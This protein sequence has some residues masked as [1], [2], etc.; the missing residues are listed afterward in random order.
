MKRVYWSVPAA[1]AAAAIA[2]TASPAS[3]STQIHTDQI[4]GVYGYGA[5]WDDANGHNMRGQVADTKADGNCAEVWLDFTTFPH[6][7]HDAYM[8]YACGNGK[9][10]WSPV[11]TLSEA[12]GSTIN[13][14]RMAVC[15]ATTSTSRPTGCKVWNDSTEEGQATWPVMSY[16]AGT[17]S[18][19]PAQNV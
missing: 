18:A 9:K 6:Q 11:F 14:F 15:R 8:V 10:G 7:H 5:Y 3:A 19:Y 2:L 4:S 13:G 17:F 12:Q 16:D 1:V